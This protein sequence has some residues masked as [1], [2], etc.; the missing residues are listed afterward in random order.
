MGMPFLQRQQTPPN[1]GAICCTASATGCDEAVKSAVPP[2]PSSVASHT[3]ALTSLPA[4]PAMSG[5]NS[6][7]VWIRK[8]PLVAVVVSSPTA[9]DTVVYVT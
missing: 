3:V 1:C 2:A 5:V 8:A 9:C 7:V 6:A 4:S